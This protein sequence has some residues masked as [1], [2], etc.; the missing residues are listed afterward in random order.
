[1]KRF[2]VFILAAAICVFL[3]WIGG[4]N[5]DQRNHG[6]AILAVAGLIASILAAN[7]PC[8]WLDK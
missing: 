8:D 1:M 2:G 3:A 6:V 7:T 5:F 4:Y